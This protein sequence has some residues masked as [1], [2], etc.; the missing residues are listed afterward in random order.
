MF[1]ALKTSR[2][3]RRAGALALSVAMLAPTA[4]AAT[5]PFSAGFPGSN[6][7]SG[8]WTYLERDP[9]T[10]V[11]TNLTHLA[12][13]PYAGNGCSPACWTPLWNDPAQRNQVPSV[14]ANNTNVNWQSYGTC[15]QAFP[16]P[17][18]CIFV[19]PGNTKDVVIH[20]KVP[21]KP[22]GGSYTNAQVNGTI[23]DQDFNGGNG[24]IWT[25]QHNHNSAAGGPLN[26]NSATLA[27]SMTVTTGDLIDV[28]VN[29][30]NGDEYFDTT[31]ICGSIVLS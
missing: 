22:N 12:M 21:A 14:W 7:G 3:A 1:H 27:Q 5:F 19:H 6:P 15:C 25:L 18:K 8:T 24:V 26:G 9:V 11:E 17:K 10:L 23:T 13:S 29:A 20:F 30:N 28:V 16:L 4:Q 2:S 31:S